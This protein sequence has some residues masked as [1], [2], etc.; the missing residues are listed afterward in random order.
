M[1]VLFGR[2]PDGE[3]RL[4]LT[5]RAHH[6][7]SHAA[8]VVF[9]G[10]HIDPGETAIDAA[11]RESTEEIGLDPG[12]VDIVCSLPGVYLTPA[13]TA[14]VPVFGWWHVPH[15]VG[16]VDPDEVRRVVVPTVA[17]LADPQNRF[18]ATA[19]GGYSGPGFRVEDLIVWGVTAYLLESVLDLT[20][21]SRPWDPS[22]TQPLPDRLLAAYATTLTPEDTPVHW[23]SPP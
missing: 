6:L 12:S 21:W 10:G 14:Y 13:R 17:E 4:V 18:T 7:R 11:L 3:T 2:E 23:P 8:Q 9:P 16:V 1:L 20:G 22:V 19:P 15:P 5:E